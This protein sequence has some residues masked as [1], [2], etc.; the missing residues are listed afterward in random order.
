MIV[1]IHLV[2]REEEGASERE[3][4]NWATY[5]QMRRRKIFAA[6]R[7]A[8]RSWCECPLLRTMGDVS[9]CPGSGRRRRRTDTRD[10]WAAAAI[11]GFFFPL[12]E[13]EADL[14]IGKSRDGGGGGVVN[15]NLSKPRGQGYAV[16]CAC[17][18][19]KYT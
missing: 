14:E 17:A 9:S 19:G 6:A 16:R 8:A 12:I 15:A 11:N 18:G 1:K 5:I 3:S 13:V 10:L 7:A 4:G 2:Q